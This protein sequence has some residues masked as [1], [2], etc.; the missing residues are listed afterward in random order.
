MKCLGWSLVP[1]LLAFL[2]KEPE[3]SSFNIFM[4]SIPAFVW[5]FLSMAFWP[6]SLRGMRLELRKLNA[7]QWLTLNTLIVVVAAP[8]VVSNYY[9]PQA[10]LAC[11]LIVI[12]KGLE[13]FVSLV[14]IGK[15]NCDSLS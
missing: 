15:N 11:V 10:A 5:Y 7:K 13:M 9:S 8:L 12:W 3:D 1:I 6:W 4:R 2:P 14:E